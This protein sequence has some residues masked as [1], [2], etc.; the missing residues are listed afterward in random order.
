KAIG[1]LIEL[2]ATVD[3]CSITSLPETLAAYQVISSAEASTNLARYDG[4]RYGRRDRSVSWDMGFEELVIAARSSGFGPEVKRRIM[5]GSCV[6]SREYA[7][8]MRKAEMVRSNI[9]VQLEALFG[10]FDALLA[11]TSP[12]VAFAF[13][14]HTDDQLSMHSSDILTI[15]ANLAGIPSLSVPCGLSDDLPVGLQIMGKRF[16]EAL[17]LRIASAYERAVGFPGLPFLK[18]HSDLV[19]VVQP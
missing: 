14:A 3:A 2:G 18:A 19:G 10:R 11:P 16:S 5:L 7:E 9:T 8:L 4:I 17:L 15:P 12:T 1:A 6:L 13:G